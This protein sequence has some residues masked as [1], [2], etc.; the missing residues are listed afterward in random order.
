MFV[1]GDFILSHTDFVAWSWCFAIEAVSGI[2]TLKK[3]ILIPSSIQVVYIPFSCYSCKSENIRNRNKSI[4][5]KL[6]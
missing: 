1:S 5:L 2:T 4:T 3:R 6:Q